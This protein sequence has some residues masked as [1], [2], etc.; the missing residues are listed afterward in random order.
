MLRRCVGRGSSV[1]V[2][3]D[4]CS[5]KNISTRLIFV[6]V[7]YYAVLCSDVLRSFNVDTTLAY[8]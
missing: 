2:A 4:S 1:A 8:R 3:P 7:T 5:G 6:I